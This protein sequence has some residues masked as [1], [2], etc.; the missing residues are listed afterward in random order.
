MTGKL[1]E[2]KDI[3]KAIDELETPNEEVNLEAINTLH[4][5]AKNSENLCQSV[6]DNLCSY[7]RKTTS[8]KDYKT[9]ERPSI[10]IQNILNLL[11]TDEFE[12]I[13]YNRSY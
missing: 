8:L 2:Q 13:I 4:G 7:I 9:R 1:H 11:F 10:K 12:R 3:I 5:I 6:Y